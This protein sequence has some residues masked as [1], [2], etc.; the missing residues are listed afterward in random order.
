MNKD[1]LR[2]FALTILDQNTYTAASGAMAVWGANNNFHIYSTDSSA[3]IIQGFK[4][5]NIFGVDMIGNVSTAY[6]AFPRI[7][8]ANADD[9]EIGVQLVGQLPQPIGVIGA[10]N[11]LPIIQNTFIEQIYTL[12]KFKT[13]VEF[14]TP[15]QS[16]KNINF[17][18]FKA[19]GTGAQNILQIRM[20]YQLTFVFYY[21][22]EG[23]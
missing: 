15:I 1:C 22:F 12:S 21:Q 11:D 9:F 3:F 19:F 16:V 6:G 8:N 23:E 20:G 2:S 5:I 14:A 18:D 13:F 4:N 10:P 7:D 17:Y